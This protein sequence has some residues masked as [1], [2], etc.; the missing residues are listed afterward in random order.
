MRQK[1]DSY[2]DACIPVYNFGPYFVFREVRMLT[3]PTDSLYKF[4][5]VFGIVVAVTG[6]LMNDRAKR[7]FEAAYKSMR[8]EDAKVGDQQLAQ[9]RK[10]KG[11]TQQLDDI[12]PKTEE[13]SRQ[14]LKI[15]RQMNAPELNLSRQD[16]ERTESYIRAKQTYDEA[17]AEY[18]SSTKFFLLSIGGVFLSVAGFYLWF[19]RLQRLL[20]KQLIETANQAHRSE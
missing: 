8:V 3:P 1:L 20:D 13:G 2:I 9:A 5:A 4:M 15:L 16:F 18:L 10:I 7:S 12:D 19:V 6:F 17:S 11:L 14:L